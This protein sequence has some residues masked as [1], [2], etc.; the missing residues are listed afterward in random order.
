MDY[1]ISVL[2]GSCIKEKNGLSFYD[3][4]F[5]GAK[6]SFVVKDEKFTCFNC[7]KSGLGVVEF[8]VLQKGMSHKRA[9]RQISAH[10]GSKELIELNVAAAEFFQTHLSKTKYFQTRK[11]D[12]ETIKKFSLGYSPSNFSVASYL[13][14]RKGFSKSL[15]EESGL[16]KYSHNN[17]YEPMSGRAVFPIK[18]ENGVIVGFGG[19]ITRSV[20]APKY[21]NTPENNL[22]KKRDL[23]YGLFDI[24]VKERETLYL[25]EGYMDVISLHQAGVNNS[26]AA[27]G[28]ATGEHHCS[29]MRS[30]GVRNVILS[31]DGD[32]A[33]TSAALRTIPVLRKYFNVSVLRLSGAKDPDEFIKNYGVESFKETEL[34]PGDFFLVQNSSNKIAEAISNLYGR[35]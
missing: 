9:M 22:F 14:N 26:V 1:K 12:E 17:I 11:I 3:C 6:D 10:S 15:I 27:L 31:L 32:L 19:R 2:L 35:R 29:L 33:G 30:L 7:F 25:V 13:E 4:P 24:P 34:I 20:D 21:I 16:A 8:L 18:D 23:L 28:T 5:C